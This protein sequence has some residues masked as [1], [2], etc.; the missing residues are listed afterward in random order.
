[1]T[2]LD[3]LREAI[4]RNKVRT[5]LPS[6]RERRRIRERAG[7]SQEELAAALGVTGPA[8]S[9]WESSTRIPRDQT[10]CERYLNA[11]EMMRLE[12]AS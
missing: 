8:L 2:D 3:S 12:R 4:R 7:V 5:S 1:M 11:L 9:R 10:I 6:P